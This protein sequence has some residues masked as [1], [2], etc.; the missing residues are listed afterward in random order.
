MSLDIALFP[1]IG[2]AV[3]A[4]T[5]ESEWTVVG[6]AVEDVVAACKLS[7]ETWYSDMLI[8]QVAQFVMIAPVG[9]LELDGST[10]A[11]DD[12]PELFGKIPAAW[13]SGTDFTLPDVDEVFL[14]GVG[15]GGTIGAAGGSNTHTLTIAEMPSHTHTYTIPVVSVDT[16]GVGAP[17]PVVDSLTPSTPTGSTGSGNA[18]EN[19]P[20]F[21][22]LVVAVF[23]GRG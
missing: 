13:I 4:L 20:S 8:G 17:L 7:V 18:H 10:D 16:V 2:D 22:S 9:W 19:R 21:L 15:A 6:D 1:H 14:A 3:T 12:Y 5:N 23:A 11:E